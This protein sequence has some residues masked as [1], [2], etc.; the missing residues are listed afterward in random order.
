MVLFFCLV[1]FAPS[2]GLESVHIER[3]KANLDGQITKIQARFAGKDENLSTKN[4]LA[5]QDGNSSTNNNLVTQSGN[6]STKNDAIK[7]GGNSSAENSFATQSGNSNA[8]N[9]ISTQSV[10]LSNENN[11]LKQSENSN[12]NSDIIATQSGNLNAENLAQNSLQKRQNA[13]SNEQN[14]KKPSWVEKFSENEENAQNQ[15]SSKVLI[16]GLLTDYFWDTNLDKKHD[17]NI[18]RRRTKDEILAQIHALNEN[19]KAGQESVENADFADD[20][21][22]VDVAQNSLLFSEENLSKTMNFSYLHE[23]K[24]FAK[25]SLKNILQNDAHFRFKGMLTRFANVDFFVPVR[26]DFIDFYK[27]NASKNGSQNAAQSHE[28]GVL[29]TQN[30]TPNLRKTDDLNSPNSRVNSTPNSSVNSHANSTQNSSKNSRSPVGA[31]GLSQSEK[32]QQNAQ[33]SHTANGALKTQNSTQNSAN[34]AQNS[35]ANLTPQISTPNSPQ[36]TKTPHKSTKNSHANSTPNSAQNS[37][38]IQQKN[39]LQRLANLRRNKPKLAIIIDD[40]ATREQVAALKATGLRLTPSFF[41][42]DKNHPRTPILAREFEFF[43]VHLPL[44]AISYKNE[45]LSTIEP[46]DTQGFIDDKIARIVRDFKGIRFIN[47]HTG[48]LFTQDIGAMRRL[49]RALSAHDLVFVDSVTS[50]A[51]KAALVAREFN[52]TPIKRDIFL[53][54]DDSVGFIKDKIREAVELAFNQGFAIAIAHP[55]NS[56]FKALKESKDLLN[57]VELVYLDEIY[58]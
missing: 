4:D 40:M 29:S 57:L 35:H 7:Q 8:N 11:L 33:K 16:K 21:K 53:D 41:P 31:T 28:N 38:Q 34:S 44:S 19:L 13:N 6:S 48:S 27:Q 51:T 55:K 9:D 17:K 1:Y 2:L 45:E 3:F 30:F 43:M 54:N 15:K 32:N 23:Q 56:T 14:L 12:A 39:S 20:L 47:N 22:A 36:S 52:Q 24:H 37:A 18:M 46:T 58:E 49:F 25:M 5:T 26:E 10:N 50:G 42:P